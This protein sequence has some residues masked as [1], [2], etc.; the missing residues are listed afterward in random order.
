MTKRP[1]FRP[2]CVDIALY[3]TFLGYAAG[4]M[5]I[6]VALV[7]IA[8]SLHFPLES[9]GMEAGGR[10]HAIRSV[11][12]VAALLG[13]GFLS[14]HLGKRRSLA[15]SVLIMGSGLLLCSLPG[16]MPDLLGGSGYWLLMTALLFAGIGE[17]VIEGLATPYVQD[18]HPEDP[19]RYVNFAH[20]FW[21]IGVTL[22]VLTAGWL[23]SIGCPWVV[24]FL[25]LAVLV[26]LPG[27]YLLWS[28][29]PE[30]P[31]PAQKPVWGAAGKI[32]RRPLFW[33]FFTAM[34]LVGG[35][36]FSLT[37]WGAAFVQ[38]DLNGSAAAGGVILAAFSVGMITGRTCAGLLIT[39]A[40]LFHL[41]MGCAVAG[42]VF[43]SLVPWLPGVGGMVVPA[44]LFFC[45]GLAVAPFWASLQCYCSD[46]MPE[47]DNTVL[48]I[49]LSLAGVPG[50][51]FF[52]WL[53]GWLGNSIG[54]AQ[55]FWIVPGCFAVLAGMLLSDRLWVF[56]R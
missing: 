33:F 53:L 47:V 42:I 1:A 13:C 35:A 54:L 37:F 8:E 15:A 21:P 26:M 18:L 44:L 29:R 25:V 34:F 24:L 20:T 39:T 5:I 32:C 41:L 4:S 48:M 14:F 55:A 9:G 22:T 56:R 10:L 45:N 51:G 12:I 36:E 11:G 38:L 28:K 7:D 3:L 43:A 17:G 50:C 6:P 31:A 16:L 30:P 40:R 2:G 19:A 49:L 23:L 52:S 46:R 27:L